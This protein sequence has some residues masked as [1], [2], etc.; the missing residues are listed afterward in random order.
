MELELE[1]CP[2]CGENL[3][4]LYTW[5]DGE[6]CLMHRRCR[7]QRE[8]TA[9]EEASRLKWDT[10]RKVDN[11]YRQGLI[12]EQHR[13]CTFEA[14]DGQDREA[15]R[16]C[17][18]YVEEWEQMQADNQGLLMWGDVGGGKTFYAA[19]IANALV[20]RGVMAVMTGL[21]GLTAKMTE[22][23]GEYRGKVLDMVKKAPLL[24]LDDVGTERS[25][26]YANELVYEVVNQRYTAKK[27]LIVTTNL[28]VQTL[29]N[30]E[31]TDKRRIYDRL[32]EMCAPLRVTGV[33]RRQAIA[34][35]KQ[36]KLQKIL[37]QA[38]RVQ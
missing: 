10:I 4:R 16:M 22:N 36:E 27:P 11:L 28:S 6:K 9:A 3:N 23:K 29:K 21:P 13:D 38:P 26:E 7:C 24:V 34:R 37:G 15:S 33:G 1:K 12:G 20:D 17:R 30:P 35:G 5:G 32:M 18:R 14:D 2:V 8:K 19:C 25:T 31:S